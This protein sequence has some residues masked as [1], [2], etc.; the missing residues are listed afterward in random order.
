[1]ASSFPVWPTR[2]HPTTQEIGSGIILR[3]RLAAIREVA[4]LLRK[5]RDDSVTDVYLARMVAAV[6]ADGG[7]GGPAGS[8]TVTRSPPAALGVRV[9]VP[10]CAS[11]M[12]LTMAR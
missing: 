7:V 2:R 6:E 1:M 9:R 4:Y 10:S 5:I 3:A 11:V 8:C 12:L